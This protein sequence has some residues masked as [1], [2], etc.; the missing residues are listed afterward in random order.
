MGEAE[1]EMGDLSAAADDAGVDVAAEA[2]RGASDN[3]AT[4][5]E[6]DKDQQD[7]ADKEGL[8]NYI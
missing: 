7:T 3:L 6:Q 8:D 4:E 1:I 2:S 5:T